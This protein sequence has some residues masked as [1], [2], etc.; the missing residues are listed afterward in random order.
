MLAKTR[1]IVLH[2]LKYGDSGIICSIYTEEFGRRSFLI[3]GAR[4]KKSSAGIVFFQSLFAL[5]IEF[6]FKENRDLQ[7]IR[8]VSPLKTFSHFPFDFNKGVQAMFIAE[9]LYKC[10]R[11]EEK[12]VRLFEFLLNSI[13]Y[14]DL[15]EEGSSNFH[16]SFLL[17]LT[18]FLGILP[19]TIQAGDG[20][21]FDIKEGIFDSNIPLHFNFLDK[22]MASLMLKF[23]ESNYQQT[24]Q[25]RLNHRERNSLLREILRFYTFHHFPLGE[26]KSLSV[27]SEIYR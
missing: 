2:H 25:I 26:L 12:N 16:L 3:K 11:E 18:S 9:V 27:L 6:Y 14:F 23:L 17:K 4:G 21:F 22:S 13:E 8:E 15:C 24:S 7:M 1:G 19:E 10:L 5:N 20:S